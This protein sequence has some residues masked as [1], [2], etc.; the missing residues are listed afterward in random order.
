MSRQLA[1][2]VWDSGLE[3]RL[4]PLAAMLAD[5]ASDDGTNV[6]PSIAYMAWRLSRERRSVQY[7][8]RELETIGVLDDA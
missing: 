1:G 7:L 3:A 8:L 5:F 2:K 6:F 4:K